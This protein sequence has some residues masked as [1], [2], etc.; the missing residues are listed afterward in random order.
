MSS[1]YPSSAGQLIRRCI[2][3]GTPLP[4]NGT[5][6][7]NCGAYHALPQAGWGQVPQIP[8]QFQ[9]PSQG[10]PQGLVPGGS[11]WGNANNAYNAPA[12]HGQWESATWGQPSASAMPGSFA[13]PAHPPPFQPFPAV[14]PA[15]RMPVTNQD[16]YSRG[17]VNST[18]AGNG[19]SQG[20]TQGG[21]NSFAPG[22]S[23]VEHAPQDYARA[24][25]RHRPRTGVIIL[26]GLLL[27]LV[28]CGGLAG[29]LYF[30]NQGQVTPTPT[31]TVAIT[32]PTVKPL[33]RD[34]FTNNSTGWLVTPGA[35][36]FSAQVG[37][38]LMT[39]EDDENRLLW[40]ILPGKSFSDFRLDV[41]ASLTKGDQ[42]NAYGVYFRGAST[43]NSEIGTYYR[44][45]IYGD[46]TFAIFKGTLDGNSNTLNNQVTYSTS[47][48]P[49][50]HP[51][52]QVNHL[53]IIA[54]GSAM[55]FM[56]NG[57]TIYN[58]TDAT[59]RGGLVA[60]FVSN[61]PKVPPGAQATF[62]NLAIFPVS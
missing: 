51:K 50:I 42:N 27:L 56:V 38:G 61:L 14:P 39:L 62:A 41:D 26:L 43:A 59:Y 2:R 30:N 57:V 21:A 52:G 17:L 16:T 44:L 35:G 33:F 37:G 10:Q 28:I 36:K 60:L 49:A 15:M 58:Y 6:C 34:T 45:E 32:T 8:G 53:T 22:F 4:P 29:V 20:W 13:Q 31:P 23:P 47:P 55:T 24:E 46:G 54:K 9:E 12:S 7:G 48:V 3:C 11:F 25:E 18:N 19:Y 5:I 1:T 40:D